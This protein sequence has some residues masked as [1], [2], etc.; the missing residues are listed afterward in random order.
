LKNFSIVLIIILNTLLRGLAMKRLISFAISS[1]L[2]LSPGIL[3]SSKKEGVK[4]FKGAGIGKEVSGEAKTLKGEKGK[5]D[6]GKEVSEEAKEKRRI[7]EH[8]EEMKEKQETK[9]NKK[10]H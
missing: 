2:F 1:I 7:E 5:K 3:Y 4:E 9:K 6:F 8:K 10:A